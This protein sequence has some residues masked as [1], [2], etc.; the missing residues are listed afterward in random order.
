MTATVCIES[1]SVSTAS[2]NAPD[3]LLG[4]Y[5]RMS[6]E[7]VRG[8]GVELFDARGRAYLDF[9]SGIAV[10]ALGYGDAGV[11]CAMQEGLDTGLIHVSN[12]YHTV[13]GRLLAERLVEWSG[14]A[15]AFFCNSGAEA[16]EG[17]F[18]F[19]RR[20]ARTKGLAKTD[21]IAL[22]GAFHGRL[23]G[24]LAATDRPQYRMPFR[25]L[26]GG[27]SIAERD[28]DDLAV[29]LDSETVAALIVE[30]VQ[31]EGGVRV[32]DPG[33][34]R[35]VRALTRERDVALIL[36]E[37]QCGLGRTGYLFAHERSGIEPDALTLAKPLAGGLPMGAI[38]VSQS[39]ADTIRP[40]DHGTTF[41]GGPF[42]ANVA[43]HI[44][45]RLAN[46]TLLTHVRDEGRR[47]GE[48]LENLADRSAKVR[49]VRGIGF[50]WGVDV[51]EPAGSIVARALDAGLLILSAGDYTL[52]IMPPLI[53]SRDD[54]TRGVQ[55]LA[56][57]IDG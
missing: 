20:W 18:K 16:N 5:K 13:P 56:R 38:L 48:A 2:N 29:L 1:G 23:F 7:F 55:M 6:V 57:V 11:K 47:L 54:L 21:I 27:I 49:A 34:L 35:E 41:G 30:P 46:P 3:G 8:A 14:L 9:A 22:R 51:V 37:I 25:P 4:V 52:R 28:L 39:I 45:Q 17:A 15:A 44:V 33:F 32:L 40:G 12:L 24:T 50:M 36:D 53:A 43:L 10:N 19:A 26:A 42:V 31:G